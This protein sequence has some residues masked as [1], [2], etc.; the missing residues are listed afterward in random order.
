MLDYY[1]WRKKPRTSHYMGYLMK[2]Q[3]DASDL[4]PD[5]M[6][7]HAQ[8]MTSVANKVAARGETANVNRDGNV[9]IAAPITSTGKSERILI[10]FLR[11]KILNRVFLGIDV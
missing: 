10:F 1:A 3:L 2:H 8:I 7:T 5:D 9:V 4:M 11:F 6:P